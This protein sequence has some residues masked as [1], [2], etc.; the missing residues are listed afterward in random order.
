MKSSP[1]R[2]APRSTEASWIEASAA[3]GAAV[4]ARGGGDVAAGAVAAW[5]G[6]ASGAAL[7]AHEANV[8]T[9]GNQQRV[10]E[11][12]PLRAHAHGKRSRPECPSPRW[13]HPRTCSGHASFQ[14]P[15]LLWRLARA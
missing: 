14:W 1:S 7:F 11:W 3:A 12:T 9:K 6:V 10:I 4:G 8:R 15:W 13:L 5:I 2:G